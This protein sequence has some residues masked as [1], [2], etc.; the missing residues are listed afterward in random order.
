[1]IAR[2]IEIDIAYNDYFIEVCTVDR[3]EMKYIIPALLDDES[4]SFKIGDKTF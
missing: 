1:M 2:M 3:R 4:N